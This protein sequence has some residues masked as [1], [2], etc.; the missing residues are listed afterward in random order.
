MFQEL[1]EFDL[2]TFYR[3]LEWVEAIEDSNQSLDSFRNPGSHR[4]VFHHG[5]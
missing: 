3:A 1:N 2:N 5:Y 4:T